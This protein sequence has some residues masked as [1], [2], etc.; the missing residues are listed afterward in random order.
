MSSIAKLRETINAEDKTHAY[1]SAHA[2]TIPMNPF[3]MAQDAFNYACGGAKPVLR[4]MPSLNVGQGML[5]Y[6]ATHAILR[7]ANNQAASF[8]SAF[9]PQ[10]QA[11]MT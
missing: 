7:D 3:D 4:D 6:R 10:Q 11:M 5:A 8:S 2:A 9:P 1:P